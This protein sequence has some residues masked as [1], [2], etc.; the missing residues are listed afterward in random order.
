[1]L[2]FLFLAAAIATGDPSAAYQSDSSTQEIV[3]PTIGAVSIESIALGSHIDSRLRI[4]VPKTIFK[5][6]DTIYISVTMHASFTAPR[7]LGVL[8]TYGQGD[9]LQAVHDESRE[10]V[11]IGYGQTEFHVAKPD[12]WPEGQYYAE[13]FMNGVSVDKLEFTVR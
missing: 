1:M 8:W 5:P 3:E 13:V 7:T 6:T 9:N 12:G 11:F 2:K 10:L 4:P